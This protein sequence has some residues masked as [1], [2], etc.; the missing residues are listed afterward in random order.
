MTQKELL[1]QFKTSILEKNISHAYLIE[2]ENQTSLDESVDGICQMIFCATSDNCGVC[3]NCKMFLSGNLSPLM[4]IGDGGRKIKKQEITEL[5]YALN[6][7]N[8]GEEQKKVY[9][10]K[11][12]ELLGNDSGNALL[13]TLEEPPANVIAFLLT[14]NRHEVLPTIRS[15]CKIFFI[16]D[17][18]TPLEKNELVDILNNNEKEKLFSLSARLRKTDRVEVQNILKDTLN[19]VVLKKH[20]ELAAN[21]YDAIYQIK[22]ANNFNLI[23]EDLF[24]KIFEVM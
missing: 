15:R 1:D 20:V 18:F 23:L 22:K 2:S 19:K 12:A 4:I 10:I 24:I 8:I 3:K 5:I 16:D 21:F 13:K 6:V 9:V 7:G 14:Q 11:N 17:E